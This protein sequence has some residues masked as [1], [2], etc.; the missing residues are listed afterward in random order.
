M[1]RVAITNCRTYDEGLVKEALHSVIEATAFPDCKDK[2]VLVKANVVSDSAPSK[3]ITTHPL[4]VKALVEELFAHGARRVLVGDSPGLPGPGFAGRGCGLAQV[5]AG[6]G[7]EWADFSQSRTHV[8]EGG[9]KV[10]MASVLDEVDFV[11]SAAKFKT[12][13]LM[14]TTGAVKNL[15]G[16][17]PG[18]TKSP[19]HLKHPGREDFA[20]FLTRLYKESKTEWALIDAV[21]GMEGAGPSN[22]TLR[23]VGLLMGGADPFLVDEAQ[24][25]IMGYSPEDIPLLAVGRREGLYQPGAQYSLLEAGGLRI[26][27]YDRIDVEKKQGLFRTLILPF[28]TK[29]FKG[30]RKEDRPAPSFDA[31]RCVRCHR[32]IEVCPAKALRDEG[33]G[34]RIDQSACIRCYCCAEF[35]PA[36]AVKVGR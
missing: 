29:P 10:Q 15:F 33:Q 3:G 27:D 5:C 2:A 1:R 7:A 11:V 19:M 20:L 34:I 4:V 6:T 9:E 32:C 14:Y 24:A 26:K 18:L 36:D 23:P 22:G 35:C 16:L 13:Q 12:H 28:L 8:L 31:Q 25:L 17:M 30:R 21:I